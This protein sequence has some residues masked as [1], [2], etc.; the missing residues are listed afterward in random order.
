MTPAPVETFSALEDIPGIAHGFIT[1]VPELDARVERASAMDRLRDIH[2]ETL[3]AAG[4][5]SRHFATAE[6]VHGDGVAIADGTFG[7]ASCAMDADALV[8]NDPSVCL[9]IYVADCAAVYLVDPVLRVIGLAHSG[10]KGTELAITIKTIRL[11]GEMM[12]TRASDI[13]VQISPC[14][15][16]PRYETDFAATIREQALS[17]GVSQ[18]FDCGICTGSDLAKYYS[19]RME[20][21]LTGRMLAYLALT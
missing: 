2:R 9:G 16:P 5:G 4:T 21:G 1:R 18:V 3:K 8:T 15:R 19:Y 20:K 12:G 7:S 6:Q 13:V 17:A 14:I 10:K 11:M